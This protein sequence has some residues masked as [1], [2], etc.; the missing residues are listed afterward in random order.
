MIPSG[1][2][3][4]SPD[5]FDSCLSLTGA[6]FP[7]LDKGN[8]LR[9]TEQ[10]LT[11]ILP[12]YKLTEDETALIV[13]QFQ[14]DVMTAPRDIQMQRLAPP[15]WNGPISQYPWR[16]PAGMNQSQKHEFYR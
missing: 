15:F 5:E 10:G 6:V 2:P 16:L 9:T 7:I 8:L 11:E 4:E 3:M 14:T 13:G 1:I 12:Q